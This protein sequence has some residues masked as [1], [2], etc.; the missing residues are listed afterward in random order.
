MTDPLA[1]TGRAFRYRT[2]SLTL[3]STGVAVALACAWAWVT[4][5]WL[6]DVEGHTVMLAVAATASLVA[7]PVVM[8]MSLLITRFA[9][10]KRNLATREELFTAAQ[11]IGKFGYWH[12][13]LSSGRFALSDNVHDLLGD[14]DRQLRMSLPQLLAM[15][16]PED[17]EML[18]A[19]LERIIVGGTPEENEYRITGPNGIEKT[20]WVDGRR[21]LDRFGKPVRAYGACQDITDRKRIEAAL[22]ESEDHYRHAVELN[23]QIPWTA[24][25]NGNLLEIGPLWFDFVGMTQE[26]ALDGGWMVALH[27]EDLEPTLR[28]WAAACA[29]GAPSDAE[30]RLR[31]VDG[32]Y[33]W[34]R[35]RAAA[36]RDA[37]GTIIRWYGTLE[38]IHDRKIADAALRRSEAFAHSILASTPNCIKVIGLKGDLQYMNESGSA[39]MQVEDLAPLLGRDWASFWPQEAQ[40]TI[41]GALRTARSGGV[42]R[43]SGYCPTAKGT[44]KWWEVSVSPILG[45]DG[46]PDR[47]L[48]I[49]RDVTAAKVAQDE[50]EQARAAAEDA[51]Q[52]LENVLSSTTDCVVTLDHAF[53]ITYL[54]RRAQELVSQGRDLLG[55]HYDDAFP[56]LA[57]T[58]FRSQ[59]EDAFQRQEPVQF[60]AY[61]R[62][63][64]RWLNLHLYPSAD[65]IS[66]F[67]KDVSI[68]RRAQEQLLYLAHHDTLTGLVNRTILNEQLERSL[69]TAT[70]SRQTAL[71]F[72]DLDEFKSINDSLGHTAGDR[73]LIQVSE[74]LSRSVRSSDIVARFG[75]DEFAIVAEVGNLGE[76]SAMAER[77]I[78]TLSE[79]YDLGT[80][81][82]VLG[83]SIGI[84][85]VS[86]P[87]I[88]A[89]DALRD[90]DIALYRAKAE[91]R[92]TF[93]VFEAAMRHRFQERQELK[94]DLRDALVRDE[95]SIDYQPLVDLA[96]NQISGF[97]A[98]LRWNHPSRGLIPPSVF[99]P[100]AEETDLVLDIGAW[101]LDGACREAATWPDGLWVAVNLSPLQFRSGDL[102]Q[103]VARCLAESGLPGKRLQLEITESVLLADSAANLDILHGLR[104]LGVSIAMDDFGTGYS[105]LNYLRRFPFDKIKID[106][107]FVADL[108]AES[109]N[110]EANAI[111][112][113]IIDLARSLGI[114]TTAEG[115]ETAAQLSALR[116]MG[117]NEVQGFLFSKAILPEEVQRTITRL[118]S[119]QEDG[120]PFLRVV[121]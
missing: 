25:P 41:K 108:S 68:R 4:F 31:M 57:E 111:V 60:E 110:S 107:A 104:K 78:A 9:E 6:A 17:R 5:P 2:A 89:E 93:R 77:I 62:P 119:R 71:L 67:F 82:V 40:E 63:F 44:P 15:T 75:G 59:L 14:P 39:L 86:E 27:P 102:V 20:F 94:Q 12:F 76:A 105:S 58:A 33:R 45:A 72:L 74:R 30:Y 81:T 29:S 69:A 3:A 120:A 51:A 18:R 87:G 21:M 79:P 117:C 98:L 88:A 24:D 28:L 13:D 100:M 85:T 53:R 66:V 73:L 113:A 10:Q 80:Q 84:I 48:S 26:S 49:S 38:D 8:G 99:V 92:G 96:T 70:A 101:V 64:D 16:N 90:A 56:E 47:L 23:P 106:R 35:A 114:T 116:S 115:V 19:A 118:N 65:G 103:T 22:R 112:R 42:A 34:F 11:Q 46:Q 43:F 55:V 32:S 109:S 61:F 97:E 52:R 121:P 83:V 37:A 50:L 54:N 1:P 91:G 95:F 36:R 7:L